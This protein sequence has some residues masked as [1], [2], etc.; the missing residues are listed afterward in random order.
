M[1]DKQNIY[2]YLEN[3]ILLDLEFNQLI[4]NEINWKEINDEVREKIFN[5]YNSLKNEIKEKIYEI[6]DIAK[7]FKAVRSKKR[8]LNLNKY[9]EYNNSVKIKEKNL[10]I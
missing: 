6:S 2:I 4:N 3:L 1:Y 9:D 7:L 10:K 8:F 5:F